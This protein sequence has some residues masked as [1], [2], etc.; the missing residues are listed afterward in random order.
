MKPLNEKEPLGPR[1]PNDVND[2]RNFK[3]KDPQMLNRANDPET[4]LKAIRTAQNDAQATR[5]AQD[6]ASSFGKSAPKSIPY[7]PPYKRINQ[8]SISGPVTK[9][10]EENT[11]SLNDKKTLSVADAVMKIM[12]AEKAKM[13]YDKDGKVESPKA[14]VLGSRIRAAKMA[15]KLKEEEE[16]EEGWN[17]HMDNPNRGTPQQMRH[18]ADISRETAKNQLASTGQKPKPKNSTYT[19]GFEG[20]SK[21]MTVKKEEVELD[22]AF[23][24]VADGEKSLRA[25]EGKTSKGTVTKTKTGLVHTRDYED[26]SDDTPAKKGRPTGGGAGKSTKKKK[27]SEMIAAYKEKGIDSL[28]EEPDNETFTKEIKDQKAKFDGKKK[29]ADVAKPSVQAV[30]MEEV[31]QIDEISKET[32]GKYL[33]APQGKGA[34]KY[35]T[36]EGKS[37]YPDI[38]TMG[39][40]ANNVHRALARSGSSSLYKKPSFYKEDEQLENMEQIDE[41]T[42]TADETEKKEK[43]VKSM[44]KGLSGFK[45]RYGDRAK[46]VMYATATKMAKKD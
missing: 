44:K 16:L 3:A 39:K 7:M 42:L 4:G 17:D 1:D 45:A 30:K 31:E 46:E 20:K 14:E 12:E 5:M 6:V 32:A 35:K 9:A 38:E 2:A 37:S 25:K 18:R 40:H 19:L 21:T 24:T 15:G 22:E 26:D 10:N 11:M 27:L 41:R 8:Q 13:D 34:N 33:T 36:G 28:Y 43:Y 29:G 23:P